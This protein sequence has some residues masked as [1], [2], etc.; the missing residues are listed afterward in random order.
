[1]NRSIFHKIFKLIILIIF[2]ILINDLYEKHIVCMGYLDKIS[3]F[4]YNLVIHAEKEQKYT[5]LGVPLE[6]YDQI[7]K[8]FSLNSD[9]LYYRIVSLPNPNQQNILFR[10]YYSHYFL[11]IGYP[12]CKQFIN[13][14]FTHSPFMYD[15]YIRFVIEYK[16]GIKKSQYL[17]SN[18]T[19]INV[20]DNYYILSA[21]NE[22]LSI[23]NDKFDLSKTFKMLTNGKKY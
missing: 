22:S 11:Q 2:V 1:M 14:P 3:K 12:N 4:T 18:G 19:V 21:L 23:I 9:K 13:Y 8:D 5:N 20:E 6:T 16:N 15:D 17:T 10:N 7:I